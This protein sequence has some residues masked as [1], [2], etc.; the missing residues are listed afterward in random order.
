MCAVSG[1]LLSG[2]MDSVALAFRERPSFTY[3]VDYG[4]VAA[5]GELRAARVVSLELGIPHRIITVNCRAIGSG[6][7]AGM[8]PAEIAPVPEWWPFRN[9]LLI[10]LSAATALKDGVSILLVG[11]VR[12]DSTHKDGT[13]EFYSLVD[14][15]MRYQEG[16]LTIV[17]PAIRQTSEELIQ[18]SRIPFS[19]LAWSH[20]CHKSEYACG[21]CRGCVKHSNVMKSLGYADY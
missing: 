8:S 19:L 16:G 4:Q 12:S 2:G 15:L 17:A 21:M 18:Q 13:P 1:L 9:Q 20:S 7:M 3:T 11:S 14:S 10:T 6:D 5:A